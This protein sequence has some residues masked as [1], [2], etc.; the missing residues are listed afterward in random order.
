VV[1]QR[2]NP[3]EETSDKRLTKA[4]ADVPSNE[5]GS[6]NDTDARNELGA[7]AGFTRPPVTAIRGLILPDVGVHREALARSLDRRARL[8]VVGVAA[9]VEEA[10]EVLERTGPEIVLV[11]L[12]AAPTAIAVRELVCAGPGSR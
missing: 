1:G 9:G 6:N 4:A 8:D 10:V 12:P 11:D 3:A 7:V 5:D 2:G